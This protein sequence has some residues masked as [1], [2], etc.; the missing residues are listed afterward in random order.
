MVSVKVHGISTELHEDLH[1][2]PWRSLRSFVKVSVEV[3]MELRGG[4]HGASTKIS[5]ENSINQPNRKSPQVR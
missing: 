1:G 2:A 5:T 3:S 4:L